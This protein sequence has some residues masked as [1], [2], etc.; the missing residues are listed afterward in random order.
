MT[1]LLDIAHADATRI[2]E[3]PLGF[4]IS[5]TFIA[6]TSE[7]FEVLGVYND[8]HQR[9]DFA[10]GIEFS[11]LQVTFVVRKATLDAAKVAD[12]I[13]EIPGKG[14]YFNITIRGEARQF[15]I[16]E[17]LPDRTLG[18]IVYRLVERG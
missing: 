10:T 11:G 4:S 15:E 1:T 9:V 6:P 12:T 13:P 7:T 17:I 18:Y 2:V 5:G 16:S 14:W 3:N 8:I